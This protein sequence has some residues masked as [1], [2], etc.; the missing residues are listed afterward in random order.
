MKAS[1]NRNRDTPNTPKLIAHRLDKEKVFNIQ[2][3]QNNK[4]QSKDINLISNREC[5][6]IFILGFRVY[7]C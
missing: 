7:W 2:N 5:L 4:N 3:I 6:G 1:I